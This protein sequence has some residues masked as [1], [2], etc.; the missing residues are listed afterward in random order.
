MF[1]D[2]RPNQF[3]HGRSAVICKHGAVATSQPLAA[4][5]GLQILRDGGNAVDAA[6][7]TA[8][9]LNVVEPMSTG[10]GGDAFMLVYLQKEKQ[11]R[12]L[13]ASGR[14]PYA[15]E[16]DFFT[17]KGITHIPS[18]GSMYSVTVPGTID[19]WSTLLDECGTMSLA[20]VLQ[21]AI[22]Y[23]ENG[24]PVSPQISLSWQDSARMLSQHPD[25]ARTYL[26]NG[27]APLPGE[28]YLQPNIAKTFRLIAEGGRDVF[29]HG[30]IAEK[31]VQFSNENDGLFTLQDFADHKSNW[32]K[33]IST[34]YRGFDIYEIPP[35][36]QGLAALLALNIVE[37]YDIREMGHNSPEHIHFAVEAMKL[38]FADLYENVTDPTF[39]DIPVT[40]LLSR[41]YTEKQRDR[42][43]SERANID[44][45]AGLSPAGSDTVYLSVVDKDRNVVSFINSIF[46]GFG[47]GLVAG[48]T[49]IMLQNR[50]AGF[51]LNPTHANCIAPHKRTLHTIIP[52]MIFDSE[53]PLVS[54]GVMGG[55]MQPQ[56][57]LQ[58]VSNLVDFNMDVQSA[59]DAPRF[60]VIDG[61]RI[62]LEVGIPM[63]TQAELAQKGHHIVPGST[64]FG[65]G[66]A[67]F[68]NPL[69]DTLHAGSDPRRD[70]CAAGY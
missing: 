8:A 46:A 37:G 22:N 66:Q 5:G 64:F 48:D 17:K 12:G 68:I 30:E 50:G 62:M 6:V 63:N 7:A 4:Q 1:D 33:P 53:T 49:G 24:F 18:T 35:N 41:E 42:I 34:N 2:Y 29:Y 38:A 26:S 54:F 32:V 27:K 11:L 21:P 52:G 47:S 43:S 25:T 10:I 59:L 36:G 44:P 58:F 55:Q 57:H 31:I 56:G 65:G 70:G 19:G 23:A 69:F 39:V 3:G 28:I 9:I 67:I 16:L 14:S 51:S 13:N 61:A 40:E 15:A 20:E 45:N 60:R